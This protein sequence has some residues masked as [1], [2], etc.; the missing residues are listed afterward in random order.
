MNLSTLTRIGWCVL[1]GSSL[2]AADKYAG[3]RPSKPDLPYLLHA[4]QLVPTEVV[5]AREEPRKEDLA[6]IVTGAAAGVK[7]PLAGPIFIMQADKLIPEK[8]S[9]YRFEVKNGNREVFFSKKKRKESA[10]AHRLTVTRLAEGLFRI[11]VYDSLENGE[12]GLSPDGDNRVF[13][14]Q[15]Y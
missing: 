12:Y 2:F 7:T 15:V 4:D 14:F 3:P 5:M 6:Y 1:L 13:C 11:E 9:L 10:K 8:L